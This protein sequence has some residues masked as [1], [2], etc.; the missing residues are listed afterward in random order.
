MGNERTIL[1]V[2][3]LVEGTDS[4]G[5]KRKYLPDKD[6][7][8]DVSASTEDEIREGIFQ[9]RFETRLVSFCYSLTNSYSEADIGERKL[10]DEGLKGKV[11]VDL[12]AG[13]GYCGWML[14]SKAKAR[15][16]IGVEPYHYKKI[17]CSLGRLLGS[18]EETLGQM[19]LEKIP[20]AIVGEDMAG[21][22]KRLPERSVSF[23]S[24]GI[25]GSQVIKEKS[26]IDELEREIPRVLHN[27][28]IHIVDLHPDAVPWGMRQ[29]ED[30]CL[31][32]ILLEDVGAKIYRHKNKD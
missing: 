27:E 30:H 19:H 22:L 21:F 13:E 8:I 24:C 16:Y 14:A 29:P 10:I 1:P 12:G 6:V 31:M 25:Y 32:E 20:T 5:L 9:E 11:V 3:R 18:D 23:L 15:G 4:N 7:Y 17:A 26:Y 28:G 2:E